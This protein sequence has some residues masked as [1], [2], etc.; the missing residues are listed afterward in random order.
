MQAQRKKEEMQRN[1]R[2]DKALIHCPKKTIKS[3]G[4]LSFDSS[5]TFCFEGNRFVRVYEVMDGARC[6]GELITRLSGKI[7]LTRTVN[8]EGSTSSDTT[9]LTLTEYGS[10]IKEAGDSFSDDEEVLR[11]ALK[12]KALPFEETVSIIKKRSGKE[13]AFSYASFVRRKGDL[14]KEMFCEV[15]EKPGFFVTGGSFGE[16]IEILQLS[17]SFDNGALKCLMNLGCPVILAAEAK[18]YGDE[19]RSDYLRSLSLRYGRSLTGE[20]AAPFVNFSLFLTILCDSDDARAIIEK[21]VLSYLS[22]AGAL[23]SPAIGCER[24]AFLSALSFGLIEQS[25]ARNVPPDTVNQ[26]FGRAYAADQN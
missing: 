14:W 22:R 21:T 25:A 19:E 20:E 24:N 15:T 11:E 23:T 13:S 2:A 9:Y 18:A 26:I 10:S 17:D 8:P 3:M 4:L 5:G 7:R 16:S 6:A 12:I 1:T